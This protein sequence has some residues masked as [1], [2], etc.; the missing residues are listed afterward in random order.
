[1][2]IFTE[3]LYNNRQ[4][5]NVSGMEY[6]PIFI[7]AGKDPKKIGIKELLWCANEIANGMTT[8]EG[9][10]FLEEV[11]NIASYKLN[12]EELNNELKRNKDDIQ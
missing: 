6:A 7:K 10:Q 3:L 11:I 4:T 12:V 2:S 1:M 5:L 8:S 9:V